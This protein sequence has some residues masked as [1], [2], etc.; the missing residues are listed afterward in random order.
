MEENTEINYQDKYIRL[1]AD[2]DNFRK[3]K[4]QEIARLKDTADVKAILTFADIFDDIYRAYH[5]YNA[6][7]TEKNII[8]CFYLKFKELGVSTYGKVGEDFDCDIHEAIA[9]D[10]NPKY[11]SGKITKVYCVGLKRGDTILRHAKVIVNQ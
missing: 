9:S 3:N 6:P 10:N 5:E 2:F 7:S 1:Y 4:E 11:E 8:K